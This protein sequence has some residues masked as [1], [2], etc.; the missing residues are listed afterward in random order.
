MTPAS[1]TVM[2]ADDVGGFGAGAGVRD[3]DTNLEWLNLRFSV[4]LSFNNVSAQFGAGGTF[5]G[6]RYATRA[7]L[8]TFFTDAG[9]SNLSGSGDVANFAPIQALQ[10]LIGTNDCGGLCSLALSAD[11][12][13]SDI[14]FN[15]FIQIN[16][17]G[18]GFVNLTCCAFP[19]DVE[20]VRASWLV[21]EAEITTVPE[22]AT[23]ALLVFGLAGLG[24][25]RR[26]NA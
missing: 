13:G 14:V 25:S 2:L 15:P 3:S 17:S 16:G 4:G 5:D 24:F 9:I 26:K 18:L 20:S 19:V 22:P 7:E 21:R 1:A 8:S 11:L 23:I 10:A 6:F 12:A